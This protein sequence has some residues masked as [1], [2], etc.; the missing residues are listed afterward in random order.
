MGLVGIY[1]LCIGTC[2][3]C[4][5]VFVILVMVRSASMGSRPSAQEV[6]KAHKRRTQ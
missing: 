6:S 3:G 1:L 4:V 5:V 2:V